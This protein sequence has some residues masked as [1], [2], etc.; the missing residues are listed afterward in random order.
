MLV[1]KQKYI[2]PVFLYLWDEQ[3]MGVV[4]FQIYYVMEKI[5]FMFGLMVWVVYIVPRSLIVHTEQ[6]WLY[7]NILH[8][9]Y[10]NQ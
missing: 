5:N 9:G 8:Y 2:L 6:S 3:Y 4:F 7:S 10:P 1:W